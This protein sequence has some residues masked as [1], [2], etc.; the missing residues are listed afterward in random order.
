[1]SITLK[2][3]LLKGLTV[4]ENK[5]TV[6]KYA[7]I[8]YKGPL[9]LSFY[10]LNLYGDDSSKSDYFFCKTHFCIFTHPKKEKVRNSVKFLL[11]KSNEMILKILELEINETFTGY[12]KNV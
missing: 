6:T 12:V 5:Y 2:N 8:Q 9:I 11:L 1:M 10:I 7:E 3:E 4:S